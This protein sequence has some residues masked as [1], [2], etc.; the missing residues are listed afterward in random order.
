M[1]IPMKITFHGLTRSDALARRIRTHAARLDSVYDRILRCDV[2]VEAPHR[3]GAPQYHVRIELSVPRGEIVVSRDPGP[4]ETHGDPY[5]AVRDSFRAARRQLED[6]VRRNLRGE[7]KAHVGPEHGRVVH[8]D[9]SGEWGTIEATDGRQVYFHCNSVLGGAAG[10]LQL[11]D[12]V[13]F[14]EEQGEKGPQ[15]TTVEPIGAHGRHQIP[16]SA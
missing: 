5:V 9:P 10:Q 2:A 15:A 13:R 16:A 14:A 6:H 3:R 1:Q 4:D 11:D 7:V 8:L 12:E